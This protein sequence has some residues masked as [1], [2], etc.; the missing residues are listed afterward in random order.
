[1]GRPENS[2][3]VWRVAAG[4]CLSVVLPYRFLSV[5]IARQSG[6]WTDAR[7]A[8][9][10]ASWS[11]ILCSTTLHLSVLFNVV[12]RHASAAYVLALY[13]GLIMAGVMFLRFAIALL[14]ALGDSSAA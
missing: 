12:G 3:N 4:L 5:R 9:I 13:L 1:L 11:L 10:V 7:S 6:Y 2:A 8:R 14:E